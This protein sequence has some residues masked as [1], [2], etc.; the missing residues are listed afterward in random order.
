MTSDNWLSV[1]A[2]IARGGDCGRT[3]DILGLEAR[4]QPLDWL[5]CR[6]MGPGIA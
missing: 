1:K 2:R 5:T 4:H 6:L 3:R